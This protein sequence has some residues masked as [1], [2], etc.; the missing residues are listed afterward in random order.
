MSILS[1]IT[2]ALAGVLAYRTYHGKG[3][4]AEMIGHKGP[5]GGAQG[6]AA[7]ATGSGG[8]MLS[9]LGDFFGGPGAGAALTNGLN[10][11]IK[12]FQQAGQGPTAQSWVDKGPN[13]PIEAP[14]LEKALGPEKIEWLAK[15]TGMKREELLKELSRELPQVVDKL[16]PEGRIPTEQEVPKL[17]G[18][19]TQVRAS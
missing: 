6:T 10:D 9:D 15:E 16:T 7:G 1:P 4:L 19:G 11:L 2:L 17:V 14:D 3:R 18:A 12:N 5:Q 13:K 8:N